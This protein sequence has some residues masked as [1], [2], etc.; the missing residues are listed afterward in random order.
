MT[1]YKWSTTAATNA[2]ADSTINFA[3][4]QA[5]SS[6][7]DSARAVMAAAAKYRKDMGGVT[8][9][10]SSTAYT[11]VSN[12][13]FDSLANMSGN[14][15][16]FS[17]HTTSGASPTLNV[18]SLG[19]KAINASTGVAVA[20]GALVAGSPYFATYINGSSEFILT[21]QIGALNGATISGAVVA[22]QAQQ[23]TG[24]A[25]DIVVTPG[26]QKFHPSAAKGWVKFIG[27]GTPGVTV[28][29]NVTGITDN[30]TGDW[31]ATWT[32][33]FST[34]NYA[35]SGGVGMTSQAVQVQLD[36]NAAGNSQVAQTATVQRINMVTFSGG[37]AIDG[38]FIYI[39]AFGD[40]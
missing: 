36:R 7:N 15:I 29:H 23:E 5:P 31:S 25:V 28:G 40:Q 38:E 8:T 1:F 9:G 3:E 26:R 24:T 32:T 12:Q 22:T 6:V 4:G 11:L 17:P 10:G 16:C 35:V 39:T 27:T 33:A 13:V 30:G 21:N 34:A 18:D 37:T 20:T 14:T 19:A 2:T